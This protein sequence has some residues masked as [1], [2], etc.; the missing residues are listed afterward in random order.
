MK[1]II[2]T[3]W[4]FS[5]IVLFCICYKLT[6]NFLLSY[7]TDGIFTL[8]YFICRNY[9]EIYEFKTWEILNKLIIWPIYWLNELIESVKYLRYMVK[10]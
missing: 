5:A 7:F 9:S 8:V 10:K 3:I 4:P 2:K 1:L 6:Y